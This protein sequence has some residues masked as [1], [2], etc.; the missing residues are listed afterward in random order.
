MVT[1]RLSAH[2]YIEKLRVA[3]VFLDGVDDYLANSLFA[4]RT[5]CV[6]LVHTMPWSPSPCHLPRSNEESLQDRNDYPGT[7]KSSWL[8]LRMLLACY[9]YYPAAS[10][11]NLP[12]RSWSRQKHSA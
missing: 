4:H 6:L 8:R 9:A 11:F 1:A 7:L 2:C 3:Y 5:Y 10:S 12:T